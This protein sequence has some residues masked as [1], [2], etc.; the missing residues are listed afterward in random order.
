LK[1]DLETPDCLVKRQRKTTLPK[2]S[3]VSIQTLTPIEM[4]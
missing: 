2:W 4:E 3:V 1:P